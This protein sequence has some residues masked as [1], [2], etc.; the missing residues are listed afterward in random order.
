M[1][2]PKVNGIYFAKNR[3]LGISRYGGHGVIVTSINKKR[4]TCQ[5]KTITSLVRPDN[6]SEFKPEMVKKIEDGKILAIPNKSLH[7]PHLSGVYQKPITI[8]ISKLGKSSCNF[9][10]PKRYDK[11]IHRK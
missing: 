7:S 10:Y 1:I 9:R 5:V 11:L 6:L 4:K 8:P 3:D 2:K